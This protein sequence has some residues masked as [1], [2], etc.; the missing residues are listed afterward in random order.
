MQGRHGTLDRCFS[1]S[2]WPF[3]QLVRIN[4]TLTVIRIGLGDLESFREN[5]TVYYYMWNEKDYTKAEKI[6]VQLKSVERIYFKDTIEQASKPDQ[7]E[8]YVSDVDYVDGSVMFGRRSR[9]QSPEKQPRPRSPY[10]R[11]RQR[12]DSRCEDS[13]RE[14]SGLRPNSAAET[15]RKRS[16]SRIERP[17]SAYLIKKKEKCAAYDK[18]WAEKVS[19]APEFRQKHLKE[20]ERQTYELL[21]VSISCRIVVESY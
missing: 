20:L 6:Q 12:Q 8:Y 21:R 17:K 4:S 10:E 13:E 5:E 15:R 16:S 1:W 3:R 19:K 7:R 2:C 9:S 18:R 11:K 14:E